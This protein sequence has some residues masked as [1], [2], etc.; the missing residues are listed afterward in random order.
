[1]HTARKNSGNGEEMMGLE[2]LKQC[3]TEVWCLGESNSVREREGEN[4]ILD[5]SHFFLEHQDG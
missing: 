2:R 3:L 4:R 5:S 1:M